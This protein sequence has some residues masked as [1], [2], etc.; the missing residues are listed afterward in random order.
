[1]A[2]GYGILA[3]FTGHLVQGTLIGNFVYS[4]HL[5]LFFFISGYLFNTDKYLSFVSFLKHKAK[6]ILLPYFTLGLPIVFFAAYYPL[7]FSGKS[8][9]WLVPG[10][11]LLRA[12]KD[13]FLQYIVQSRYATLWYLAVLL[14][15]NIV[16]YAVSRINKKAVQIAVVIALLCVGFAYYALGGYWLPWNVDVIPTALPFFYVGYYMKKNTHV[17]ELVES[18]DKGKRVLIWACLMVIN[19]GANAASFA[20]SGA[21]LE[22]YWVSYGIPPLTYLSA[23]A[24]L[25]AVAVFST[26]FTWRPISYIGENSMIYFLW[27]QAI[28]FE[29]WK[30]LIPALGL[31]PLIVTQ[32]LVTLVCIYPFQKLYDFLTKTVKNVVYSK[33]ET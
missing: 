4:F 5:P 7:V 10:S 18:L 16:M 6:S 1:M 25:F 22:M 13:N 3:V 9:R 30:G 24:G 11:M 8:P 19:I 29:L 32:I 14:G 17:A 21:G 15:I 26:L 31:P 33:N 27:H 12:L 28:F 23:F 20:L 2:K